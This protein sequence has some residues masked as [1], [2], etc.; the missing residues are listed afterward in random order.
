MGKVWP[1]EKSFE[2]RDAAEWA[3]VY[4]ALKPFYALRD[5]R[6][7]VLKD[8]KS[9][10]RLSIYEDRGTRCRYPH[11]NV[12]SDLT[13]LLRARVQEFSN[14]TC[15]F[16]ID[17]ANGQFAR[18]PSI[19]ADQEGLYRGSIPVPVELDAATKAGYPIKP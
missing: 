5:G 7:S 16:L 6:D 10:V 3:D 1:Y 2:Y 12:D 17:Y 8:T 9:W 4:V 19:D 14:G 11:V 15:L 18:C 13:K